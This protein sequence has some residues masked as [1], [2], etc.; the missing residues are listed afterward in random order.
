MMETRLRAQQKTA[1]APSFTPARSLLQRKCAC[2]GT[3]G[4]TGE[5]ETCDRKR[6]QRKSGDSKSKNQNDSSVPPI[7]DEVLRSTGQ[8]LDA[9][10]RAFMEPRFGHDFSQVRVHTDARAAESASA[11]SSLAYTVGHDVVMGAGS[12]VPGGR[13]TRKLLAHELTHVVQQSQS[14]RVPQGPLT[15]GA[16]DCPSE[17]EADFIAERISADYF[18]SSVELEGIA[19]DTP[20]SVAQDTRSRASRVSTAAVNHFE[21]EGP[22]VRR[23]AKDSLD[24]TPVDP[25]KIMEFRLF[26][27]Q[28]KAVANSGKLSA[29]EVSEVNAAIAKAEGA[30]LAAEKVAGAGSSTK[31]ASGVALAASG[32]L[33]AD[34][35]TVIGIADD[36]AI[37]FTLAAAG[38]LAI[39]ALILTSSDVE[40]RRTGQF[41]QDAVAEA[42]EAM[43]QILLAQKVGEQVRGWAGQVVVHLARIL[44]TTVAG[45]PPDHQN[46]PKRDK[47]HWWKE[48]KNW[49]EQ[50][51]KK[52]LSPRQLLRELR[53]KFSDEQL[54]EIR[55]AI[56]KAAKELG[57]DPPDFPP[58]AMP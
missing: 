45:M 58:T 41:A 8:P 46:D 57:E 49:I 10:T 12:Y 15:V 18:G 51:R 24:D 55:E 43:G 9:G 53:K 16:G 52:E 7:V 13:E 3:P 42:I 23:L 26:I 47:P 22:T 39:G 20:G 32:T 48:I 28:Y 27:L 44:G 5:C 17:N 11:I 31:Y 50:I 37:P 38:L 35:L 34:D 29:D 40:I 6:L 21:T 4:P 2:G 36:V 56:R 1:P 30:L 14:S 54:A 19:A 25:Q 33:A